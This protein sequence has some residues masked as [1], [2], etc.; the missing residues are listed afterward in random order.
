MKNRDD[1]DFFRSVGVDYTHTPYAGASAFYYR[2]R[3]KPSGQTGQSVVY[4]VSPEKGRKLVAYWDGVN[5]DMWDYWEDI[6]ANSNNPN[7][8]TDAT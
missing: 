7:F 8:I 4:G 5:P 2:W 6:A 3:Y 1:V